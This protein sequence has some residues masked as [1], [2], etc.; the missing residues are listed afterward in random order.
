MLF[1]HYFNRHSK[2]CYTCRGSE[3][4]YPSGSGKC[5]ASS[6]EI[7]PKKVWIKKKFSN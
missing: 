2:D 5:H 4:L 7:D 3:I 1:F 6:F